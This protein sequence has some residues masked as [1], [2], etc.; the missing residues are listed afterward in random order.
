MLFY[1]IE[2]ELLRVDVESEKSERS[3]QAKAIQS[4]TEMFFMEQGKNF[5]IAVSD[6]LDKK[7]TAILCAAMK[8]GALSCETV[9]NFMKAVGLEAG[10]IVIQEITIAMYYKL[11]KDGCN[12]DYTSY[13]KD[14]CE[15]FGID[16]LINDYNNLDFKLYETLLPDTVIPKKELLYQAEGLLCD[17]SLPAEIKRIYQVTRQ[18]SAIGHPV[19]YILQAND[20]TARDKMLRVLLTALYQNGRIKSRRYAEAEFRED[21]HFDEDELKALYKASTGGTVVASF[22]EKNEAESEYASTS[23][24]I[25]DDLCNVMRQ[26]CNKVLT[27]FCLQSKTEKVR[28]MFLEH[29]GIIMVVPIIQETVFSNQAKGY[30]RILAQEHGGSPDRKLY[31]TVVEGKGYTAAD[32]NQTFDEWYDMRLKTK[33]YKQY[34]GLE[35]ANKQIATKK[36]KGL[37]IEELGEMVGLKEAKTVIQ[38]ALDFYKVQKLFREKGFSAERPAMHMMFTGSPG[39]A[40]TTVA[41]LFAQ[42]MKDNGLLSEGNL[43]EVGRADLVGKYVGWTAKIVK[44]KFKSA[45]GSVLFIDEAYS[46]VE[47]DGL[48]GDEAINTIVQ[49]MENNREDMIVIFA[50]YPDKME[51]FLK[52]NPG[53]RSRIAFHVP[54]ADYSADELFSITELLAKKKKISLDSAVKDKLIPIFQMVMKNEDFGNGRF[55]RNL[56]EKAMLKQAGRLVAMD[57]DKMAKADIGMLFAEDFEAPTAIL[58]IKNRIGF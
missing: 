2:G 53:L 31:K 54:F 57:V 28:E 39:T 6:I 58:K 14:V 30:L 41:R 13:S 11:L 22:A 20:K 19:H 42:I 37:A 5:H 47:R 34:A 9:G 49:E 17:G 43:Y 46:L 36:Q 8:N 50:G 56:F 4:A 55:A 24:D 23:I 45:K 3:E 7:K 15:E 25:I 12:K 27:V 26:Y 35:T 51:E 18:N 38:Q 1:K 33:I 44:N 29:L 16:T 10:Q 21:Y 32:L 48:Y 40:K 52:K